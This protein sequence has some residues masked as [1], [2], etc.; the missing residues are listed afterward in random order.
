MKVHIKTIHFILLE[1]KTYDGNTYDYN[2]DDTHT[3][4]NNDI[5]VVYIVAAAATATGII[6][7]STT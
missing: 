6:Y 1:L 2:Q 4:A 3:G 5:F 7:N